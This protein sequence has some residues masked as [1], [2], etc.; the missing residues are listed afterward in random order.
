MRG[1]EGDRLEQVEG[2]R[3]VLE[4]LKAGRVRRL[5]TRQGTAIDEIEAEA[6][7]Q[8]VAVERIPRERLEEMARTDAPQGVVAECHPLPLYDLDDV[9]E[10]RP[11][12]VLVLDG[13]VDPRNLG[14]AA[15]AAEA[16]GATGMVVSRH[17][18]SPLSPAA[19]KAAAGA[20][21][22][23]PVV[24]VAGIPAAV[25]RLKDLGLW[26]AVLDSAGTAPLWD[27]PLATEPLALV[28]G[29]EGRGVG[30]LVKEL[31]DVVVTIPLTGRIGSL[32]AAS[33]A[34]VALFEVRRVRN[35]RIES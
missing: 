11:A 3:P 13:V 30:R 23:L 25:R 6:Q 21:E 33:A 5:F 14:A 29:A 15:R 4:A 1:R 28:I 22:Y 20:L 8:R 31:A 7:R 9:V 19:G 35:G 17:E 16:A 24:L 12:L 32:N 27:F 26:V 18:G 34:A 10:P 2:R